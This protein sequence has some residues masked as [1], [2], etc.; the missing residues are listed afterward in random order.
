LIGDDDG[1][2]GYCCSNAKRNEAVRE[3]MFHDSRPPETVLALE[4]KEKGHR[5][6]GRLDCDEVTTL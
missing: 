5:I 3:G 6:L 4:L 2:T 1:S